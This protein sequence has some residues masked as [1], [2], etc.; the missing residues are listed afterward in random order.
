MLFF[1]GKD[2]LRWIEQ[3]G[4]C[5][6]RLGELRGVLIRPQSFA[7][8]L[9]GNPPKEVQEKLMRWGVADYAS[10]FSRALGLNMLFVHPPE[11]EVLAEEFLRGY[12]RYADSL[13]RCFMEAEPHCAITP[14]NFQ[15][16]LYAS[17]EYSRILESEWA[18]PER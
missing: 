6:A 5:V 13:F 7:G 12:D 14:T 16:P 11:A 2:L 8:L 9:I 10:I 4:E 1:L 3:C 18:D 15:F 17:G